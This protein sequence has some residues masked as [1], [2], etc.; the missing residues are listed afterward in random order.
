[1]SKFPEYRRA[2]CV[3]R[4]QRLM[5]SVLITP[6]L[7]CAT[8][9]SSL[10]CLNESHRYIGTLICNAVLYRFRAA[11]IL[12]PDHLQVNWLNGA[13]SPHCRHLWWHH[14]SSQLA[15]CTF[16]S[17]PDHM[18]VCDSNKKEGYSW[19]SYPVLIT[20]VVLGMYCGQCLQRNVN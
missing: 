5:I 18:R 9:L 15:S 16:S 8:S 20:F 12:G 6:V 3:V 11:W 2:L 10:I 14:W 19:L 17:T 4:W 13:L 1:M 7:D